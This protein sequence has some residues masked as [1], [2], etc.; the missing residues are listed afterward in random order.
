MP[1]EK[2]KIKTGGRKPGSTNL[3]G[4]DLRG[5]VLEIVERNLS[6]LEG[7]LEQMEPKDRVAVILKMMEFVLPKGGSISYQEPLEV[8][9]GGAIS[10][11]KIEV[12]EKLL[13]GPEFVVINSGGK[14]GTVILDPASLSIEQLKALT[15]IRDQLHLPVG[16]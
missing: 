2:G 7:V 13:S 9:F 16:F 1:F 15:E 14:C 3:I 6:G 4:K 12:I 8:S 11:E 5:R 10:P